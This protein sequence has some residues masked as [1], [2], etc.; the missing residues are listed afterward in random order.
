M[1]FQVIDLQTQR[2]VRAYRTR[3]Q[4]LRFQDLMDAAHGSVRY[5]VRTD[6]AQMQ[7]ALDSAKG[8]VSTEVAR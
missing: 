3:R 7:R 2:T 4:A 5:S 8:M 6:Y 1:T